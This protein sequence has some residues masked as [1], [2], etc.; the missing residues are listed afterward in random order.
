MKSATT[1]DTVVAPL[2]PLQAIVFDFDGVIADSE[3]LHFR[4]FRDVLASDGIELTEDDYY[5]RYLGLSD[6]AAFVAIGSER[7]ARWDRT[8]IG[9]LMARKAARFEELER[10]RSVIFP[11]AAQFI[12]EAADL[13]P[14]AI[15]SGARR[16]E[17]LRILDR[18]DLT[19]WFTAIVAAEDVAA[20]K[21][22]PD[23]YLRA[24]ER[25]S[26]SAARPIAARRAVAIEDSARGLESARAA[27]LKT[28][29]VA[30]PHGRGPTGDA[31]LFVSGLAA[32]RVT[33]LQQL[34]AE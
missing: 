16:P 26:A 20:S 10:A 24:I 8:Q 29:A 34:A 7:A 25:L 2:S 14:V 21:P 1:E 19:R 27:G 3:P 13:V 23:P 32:L 4:S 30:P 12:S 28:V 33:D 22:A 18:A 9:A 5:R 17:I 11:G 31:D 6:A 15:A